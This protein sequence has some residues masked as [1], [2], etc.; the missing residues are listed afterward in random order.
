MLQKKIMLPVIGIAILGSTLFGAQY[1]SAQDA[2]SSSS[3][4]QK[5]AEKFNLNATDVQKVFDEEHAARSA[6]RQAAFEKNLSQAVTDGKITATQKD[7][8]AKKFAAM[9]TGKSADHEAFKSMTDEE[10]QKAMETK[11]QEL[12]DWAS[13]IG[14]TTEVL[15]EVLG[16][17]GGMGFHGGFGRGMK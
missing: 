3:I 11:K 12:A 15:Q 2:T 6:E 7:A 9:K 10:R 8:I 1:V 13:E 5:I 14:L 4:V 17:K 16:R